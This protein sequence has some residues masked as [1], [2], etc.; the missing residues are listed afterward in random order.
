MNPEYQHP[1]RR[2]VLGDPASPGDI[3]VME[4]RLTY[5]GRLASGS[6]A[7]GQHKHDI[8][9]AF[10]PQLKRLWKSHPN[11]K[12]RRA[13]RVGDHADAVGTSTPSSREE[14]LALDF[15]KG[16][17]RFVPL[18]LSELRLLCH[19]DVLFLRPGIPG[20]VLHGGDIDNRMK[21]LMD[22]LSIPQR[23][24]GVPAEDEDPFYVLLQ[25]DR[26]VTRLSVETD[27]LLQPTGPD[28]GDQDARLIVTVRLTPYSRVM[29]T[30]GF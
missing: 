8:R 7:S 19:V 26:L 24:V 6:S 14:E 12:D 21:T 17:F 13:W 22:A 18:V 23:E 28:A 20:Q 16:P 30:F 2:L 27:T 9:R 4:F 25:D 1:Y 29:A 10:H 5:E 3:A 11:L 15:N